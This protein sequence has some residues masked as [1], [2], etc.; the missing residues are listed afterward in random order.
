VPNLKSV[1]LDILELLAFNTQ[2]FTGSCDPGHDP[3][4]KKNFG[5]HKGTFPGSMRAKFEVRTVN[6]FGAISI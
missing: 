3:F 6:R 4:L 2:K 5:G 1:S